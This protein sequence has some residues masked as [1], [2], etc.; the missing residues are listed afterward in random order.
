MP[1]TTLDISAAL[2]VIDLQ[3]GILSLPTAHPAA[4]IVDRSARLARA[5][6]RRGQTVVLVNVTAPALGRTDVGT[7]NFSF[8]DG[9]TELVPIWS[10][11]PKTTSSASRHR[12]RSSAHRSTST[13]ASAA[14][15]RSSSPA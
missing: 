14:S 12:A 2:I 4:E 10:S 3:K 15:P 6:R 13:S 1:L 7:R 5:F 9:W 8:P 11:N